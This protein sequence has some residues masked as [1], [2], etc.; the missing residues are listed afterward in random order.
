M[1][2]QMANYQNCIWA[3][4]SG[5]LEILVGLS[6]SE[7]YQ[8]LSNPSECADSATLGERWH[9]QAIEVCLAGLG[10]FADLPGLLNKVRGALGN[11]LLAGASPEVRQGQIC[12]STPCCAAEVFFAPK[13]DIDIGFAGLRAQIAKPFVL[14]AEKYGSRDLLIRMTVFGLA[15]Y[16]GQAACEALVAALRDQV[17]WKKLAAGKYFVPATID[18]EAV[19]IVDHQLSVP[20]V[21]PKEC[22]L[23]FITPLDSERTKIADAPHRILKKLLVRVALMARWQ[24]VRLSENL[25]MLYQRW[26]RLE[27]GFKGLVHTTNLRLD[28]NRNGQSGFREVS[29]LELTIAGDLATLWPF[30]QIGQITHIGRGAVKGLGRFAVSVE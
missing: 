27:C 2:Q 22:T 13:P 6:A 10:A 5:R 24:G 19:R 3:G 4:S 26:E 28:S 18:V 20:P 29:M 8:R 25:D 15:E 30:L 11:V 14:A 1:R 7:F 23:S 16:W 21:C 12:R 17:H 9:F